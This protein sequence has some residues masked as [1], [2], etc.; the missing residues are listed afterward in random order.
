[1]GRQ[2]DG[3]IFQNGLDQLSPQKSDSSLALRST[4]LEA[5]VKESVPFFRNPI[6]RLVP[7]PS[8]RL[9]RLLDTPQD[10]PL[11]GSDGH[12]RGPVDVAVEK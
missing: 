10:I 6:S 7:T 8:L 3:Q 2:P 5:F 4:G 12:T 11:A 9:A 1:L